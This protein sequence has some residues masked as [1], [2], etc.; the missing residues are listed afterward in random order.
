MDEQKCFLV[1]DRRKAKALILCFLCLASPIPFS[2]LDLFV[3]ILV[4]LFFHSSVLASCC[5]ELISFDAWGLPDHDVR[6]IL[7]FKKFIYIANWMIF[8]QIYLTSF[9][10]CSSSLIYC[11]CRNV[12]YRL[13]CRI[14]LCQHCPRLYRPF[15]MILIT[16]CPV[17]SM[18]RASDF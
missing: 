9:P 3:S 8:S 5:L 11:R 17:S 15:C 7:V 14:A 1:K 16:N 4:V 10:N 2:L 13:A 12:G 18:V 6:M